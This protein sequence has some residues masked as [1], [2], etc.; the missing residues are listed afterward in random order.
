MQLLLGLYFEWP[1]LV[2][3][4]RLNLSDPWALCCSPHADQT[5]RPV[6]QLA[7]MDDPVVVCGVTEIAE[8][9]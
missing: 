4:P 7:R 5:D 2:L 6:H 8:M 3:Q 1:G 9:D